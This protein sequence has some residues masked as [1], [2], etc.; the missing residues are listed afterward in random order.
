MFRHVDGDRRARGSLQRGMEGRG[1]FILVL[2]SREKESNGFKKTGSEE[3][4]LGRCVKTCLGAVEK[5]E[6]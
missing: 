2:G 5:D 3:E 1:Y 4:R 6:T